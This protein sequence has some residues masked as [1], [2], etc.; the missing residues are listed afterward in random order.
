MANPV[1]IAQN[2]SFAMQRSPDQIW[3]MSE[4]RSLSAYERDVREALDIALKAGEIEHLGSGYYRAAR[5]R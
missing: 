1:I 5:R 4:L 2:L 3:G